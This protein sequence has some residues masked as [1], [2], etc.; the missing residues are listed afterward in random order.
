LGKNPNPYSFDPVNEFSTDNEENID[1][2]SSA[3][4]SFIAFAEDEDEQSLGNIPLSIVLQEWNA[5]SKCNEI[6]LS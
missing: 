2:F 5:T 3:L 4:N 6:I 1:S